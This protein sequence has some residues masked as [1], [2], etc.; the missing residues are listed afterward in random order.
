MPAAAGIY[1]CTDENGVVQF[2]DTPC[3][4]KLKTIKP[5]K[6]GAPINKTERNEKR[7]RLLRAYE[8]ERREKQQ[9]AAEETA[10]RA[11]RQRNCNIV[12][13]RLQQITQSSSL[14]NLD[15]E[16]NRVTL[17]DE[18]RTQETED[19]QADVAYWC[20]E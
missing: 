12:R 20:D 17:T 18:E 5:L 7:G 13:R 14:Y 8:D 15:E 6:S 3:D 1:K 16:G 2:G 19:T 11:K 10:E 9:R 4:K